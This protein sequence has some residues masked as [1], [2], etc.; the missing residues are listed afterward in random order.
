MLLFLDNAGA[1]A[2]VRSLDWKREFALHSDY[3]SYKVDWDK[4]DVS[5]AHEGPVMSIKMSKCGRYIITSGNDRRV[6]LWHSKTG[7]LFP[8]NFQ[9]NC[10]SSLPYDIA[11]IENGH[12]MND[13]IAVPD[14]KQG[15]I[16]IYIR[17][18]FP[19]LKVFCSY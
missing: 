4:H 13:L 16:I 9:T 2:V 3:T 5:K 6:R 19:L 17:Q 8:T 7:E 14:G 10:H 11:L 18:F 15:I 1:R 12:G